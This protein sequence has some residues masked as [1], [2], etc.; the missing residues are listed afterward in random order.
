MQ[1]GKVPYLP[2]FII[3]LVLGVILMNAGKALFLDKTGLLDETA[4]YQ[5]KYMTID[6][7]ALFL[8][9][10]WNRLKTVLFLLIL[11]TTYLGVPVV[12]G[13]AAWYGFSGG[14][15]LSALV[16]RYGMKGIFFAI[17]SIFPQYL[18][19]IPAMLGLLLWCEKLSRSL[20]STDTV[21]PESTGRAAILRRAVTLLMILAAFLVGCLLE[22]YVNPYFLSKLLKVF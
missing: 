22:S 9:V 17:T 7:N 3:G 10:L 11:A 6:S 5:M 16:I 12:G 1:R 19:Y 8:Y 13:A 14:M 21:L 18:I 15:Y 2:L 20:Y 4:L